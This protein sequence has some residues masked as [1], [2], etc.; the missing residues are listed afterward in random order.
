[1]E[2]TLVLTFHEAFKTWPSKSEGGSLTSLSEIHLPHL[3]P[4]KYDNVLAIVKYDPYS[5][6]KSIMTTGG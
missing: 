1:M 2:K 3:S 5:P 4:N 6:K